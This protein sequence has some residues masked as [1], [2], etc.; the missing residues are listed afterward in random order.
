MKTEIKTK[1][2]IVFTDLDGTFLSSKSEISSTN[3]SALH[4]LKENGIVNVAATGRNIF[5][6]NKVLT[7][8]LPFDYLIFSTGIGIMDFETKKIIKSHN[9]N[10]Q[11]SK[12]I[13]DFILNYNFNVFIHKKAPDNHHFYYKRGNYNEDFE[14]RFNLYENFGIEVTEDIEIGEVSQFVIVLDGGEEEFDRYKKIIE[15]KFDFVKIIRATSPINHKH[16]WL[17]IYPENVS[18]GSAANE[19]CKLLGVKKEHTYAIGNDYNDIEMLEFANES[20]VVENAPEFLKEKYSV[21]KSND[22]DGFSEVVLS[23]LGSSKIRK[24]EH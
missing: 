13:M 9:F 7:D 23:I 12:E 18:K 11:K 6:N 8:D 1:L 14:N 3:L 16:I 17:E 2:K 15:N 24:A 19:L 5:S 21:V 22:K 4:K 10:N 20:F